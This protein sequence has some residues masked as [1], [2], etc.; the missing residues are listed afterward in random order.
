[1]FCYERNI[2]GTKVGLFYDHANNILWRVA[3]CNYLHLVSISHHALFVFSH[4]LFAV[5]NLF[6]AQKNSAFSGMSFI[7]DIK[8]ITTSLLNLLKAIYSSSWQ[9][10]WIMHYRAPI[11]I[12]R[13]LN[14]VENKMSLLDEHWV[15]LMVAM[16]TVMSHSWKKHWG[17]NPDI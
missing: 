9:V 8:S 13:T 12:S 2:L 10:A 14:I 3:S 1:M 17:I 7:I 4:F 5:K 6:G 15:G 16:V 11:T